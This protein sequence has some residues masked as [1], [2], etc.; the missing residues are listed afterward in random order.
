MKRFEYDIPSYRIDRW[1]K[2]ELSDLKAQ[3]IQSHFND[4]LGI[5]TSKKEPGFLTN[6]ECW[7]QLSLSALFTLMKRLLG[8]LPVDFS[9]LEAVLE[10]EHKPSSC[11]TSPKLSKRPPSLRMVSR[12]E[13]EV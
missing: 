7:L 3:M 11:A 10:G 13:T 4:F 9:N 5:M 6:D 2:F 12:E 1:A 8:F